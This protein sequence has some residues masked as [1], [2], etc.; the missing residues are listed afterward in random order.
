MSDYEYGDQDGWGDDDQNKEDDP[1][2]NNEQHDDDVNVRIENLMYEGEQYIAINKP[3][4][5]KKFEEV[6]DLES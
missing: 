4:S 5:L 3:E 1:W 6:L 2:G